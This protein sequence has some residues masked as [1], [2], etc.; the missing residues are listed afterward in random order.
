MRESF[1]QVLALAPFGAMARAATKSDTVIHHGKTGVTT[2]RFKSNAY[3]TRTA[4]GKGVF[5]SV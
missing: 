5:H 1:H 3:A 2:A 4:I